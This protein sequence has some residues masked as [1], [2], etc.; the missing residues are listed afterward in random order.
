MEPLA[1]R[2]QTVNQL[3]LSG[4]ERESTTNPPSLPPSYYYYYY[5]CQPLILVWVWSELSVNS[6]LL[7]QESDVFF[8][9]TSGLS[10]ENLTTRSAVSELTCW[11]SGPSLLEQIGTDHYSNAVILLCWTLCIEVYAVW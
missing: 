2:R 4:S 5:Y 11:Y 1:S 6:S 9:P 3:A 7:F 8:V 10:G